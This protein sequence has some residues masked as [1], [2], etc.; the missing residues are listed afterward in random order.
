MEKNGDNKPTR[1]IPYALIDLWDVPIRCSRCAFAH[2][3]GGSRV[4]CM[5]YECV[6]SKEYAKR[7]EEE[8]AKYNGE[9]SDRGGDTDALHGD[10]GGADIVFD[11]GVQPHEG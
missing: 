2:V 10:D 3:I 9:D 1:I 5:V 8:R 4:V 11:A 7:V 6:K